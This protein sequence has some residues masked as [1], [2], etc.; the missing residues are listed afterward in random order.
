VT[1][2]GWIPDAFAAIMFAVAA[3]SATRLA[4]ARRWRRPTADADID[5]AHL[6]MAIAMAGMLVASLSTL[7]NDA[8]DAIFGV[9]T[10]WFAWRVYRE[11]HG[12][13]ARVLSDGHHVPHLVHS[14]AMLYMFVAVT[15]A[16]GGGSGMSTMGGASGM[17]ALRAPVLALLFALLLAGYAVLDL[18]RL[19]GPATHGSYL[20]S[21]SRVPSGVALA[22][23]NGASV[24]VGGSPGTAVAAAAV[25]SGGSIVTVSPS[26]GGVRAAAS[27][28]T[29]LGRVLLA[30]R[31]A[32][33]CRIAMGVTMAF[34]LIIMI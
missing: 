30:P 6:L 29:A 32:A 25:R 23:N 2:P 33:G 18:D 5:S 31:L 8:W 20:A 12:A 26:V 22:T 11:S 16:A 7:P 21:L 17:Q 9:M 14:A 1:T 3:I 28:R 19:S 27:D 34:M 13:G 24:L 15:A 10:A 4:L